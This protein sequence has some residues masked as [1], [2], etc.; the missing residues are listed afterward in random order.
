[1]YGKKKRDPPPQEPD[2]PLPPLCSTINR[3]DGFI[4][5]EQNGTLCRETATPDGF[6]ITADGL[7]FFKKC[8]EGF[9]FNFTNNKCDRILDNGDID[10]YDNSEGVFEVQ[11]DFR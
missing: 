3:P 11:Y 8:R 1:V 9:S 7:H 2:P 5:N 10:E 4:L 6:D